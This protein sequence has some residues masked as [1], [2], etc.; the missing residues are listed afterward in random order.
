[1]R[2]Y[3]PK[4]YPDELVY[5]WFGRFAV[6]SGYINSQL[7]QFL[8]CKRSD[9]PI[10]EFIGNLNTEA[11]ECID[12]T[13]P[14]R[15][16]VLKHTMYPQ[17]A[18]FIPLEKRKE[19]LH[20]LCHE[21][22][23]MHHLFAVLPRCE[24]EQ[25]LKYCLVCAREDRE[26]YAE[27]YW[28]RKHQIRNM[29]ICPKHKCKLLDSSVSAKSMSLYSFIT[30]EEVIPDLEEVLPVDNPLKITFAEYME[31]VFDASIDFT[32]DIPLSTIL[33]YG[34][35]NTE[36]MKATGNSRYMTK[37]VDDMTDYYEQIELNEIATMSR[38]QKTLLTGRGYDFSIACQIAFFLGMN[39]EEL[40]DSKLSEDQI[41]QEKSIHYIKNRDIS[42]WDEYDREN[43]ARFEEFCNTIYNG[44]SY[45]NGRPERVSERMIYEFLNVTAYGFKNMPRCMKVYKKYAES[46]EQ[47]WVRKIAWAYEKLK[48]ERGEQPI[49]WTDLRKLSGVKKK[50]LER[51][52]GNLDECKEKDMVEKLL[53]GLEK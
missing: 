42:D 2:M 8:Y 14:L 32:K 1:M 27:T 41:Q 43:V 30:A 39:P 47:S 9:T 44:F 29:G 31:H 38:I 23:D 10:K 5:S 11:R 52:M 7:L 28:H 17:Y 16:L 35:K 6:H 19:A 22:C 37:F 34:M 50:S 48:Q 3:F 24:K 26:K 13:Y 15:E 25:Y 36:Y 51:V 18:R 46:Y 45:N 49:Y 20:K 4:I 33:Y 21:N 53:S 12:N 40:T